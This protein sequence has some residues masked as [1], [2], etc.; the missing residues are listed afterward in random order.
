MY[1]QV[2][3]VFLKITDDQTRG[4]YILLGFLIVLPESRLHLLVMG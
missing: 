2:D 1:V 4:I 3:T